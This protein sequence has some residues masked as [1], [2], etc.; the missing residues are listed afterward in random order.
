MS[1]SEI[2]EVLKELYI[3]YHVDTHDNTIY[4]IETN[5]ECVD[6]ID[7]ETNVTG[8]DRSKIIKYFSY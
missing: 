8:W 1:N 7:I 5:Y 4:A 2:I 3:E 6:P